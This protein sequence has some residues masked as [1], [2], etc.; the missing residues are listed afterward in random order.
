MPDEGKE[1]KCWVG[2]LLEDILPVY[3]LTYELPHQQA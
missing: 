1:N 2:G 3:T